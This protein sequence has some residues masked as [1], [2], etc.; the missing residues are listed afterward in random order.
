MFFIYTFSFFFYS[1]KGWG[2]EDHCLQKRPQQG[3]WLKDEVIPDVVQRH[4]E[5]LRYDAFHSEV[6]FF[7]F[8]FP[9]VEHFNAPVYILRGQRSQ[10]KNDRL[11][12][13]SEP[14]KAFVGSVK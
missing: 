14:Y 6:T 12:K 13:C 10:Q 4:R 1:G 7:F 5:A 2:S 9:P 3:V 8:K 11:G